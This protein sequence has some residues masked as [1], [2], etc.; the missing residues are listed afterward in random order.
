MILAITA[1][2]IQAQSGL[3]LSVTA[4]KTTVPIGTLPKL[5]IKLT[6]GSSKPITL[7]RNLDGSEDKM[8]YPKIFAETRS[9]KGWMHTQ[10]GRCGNT[11]NLELANFFEL[12]AGKTWTVEHFYWDRLK[13]LFEKPGMV[14][15]RVVLDTQSSDFEHWKGFMGPIEPEVEEQLRKKLV[16]VAKFKLVSAPIDIRVI[17]TPQ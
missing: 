5:E 4:D 3:T 9:T 13:P 6:N 12:A 8:R 15:L 10:V 11:N 2:A 14:S 1:L 16:S 7:V 17:A